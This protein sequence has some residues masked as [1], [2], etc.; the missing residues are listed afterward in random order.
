MTSD[1]IM[2]SGLNLT[3]SQD[4][5]LPNFQWETFTSEQPQPETGAVPKGKNLTFSEESKKAQHDRDLQNIKD[6][7]GY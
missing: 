2:T 1:L 3:N 7:A 4:S 6:K 5:E